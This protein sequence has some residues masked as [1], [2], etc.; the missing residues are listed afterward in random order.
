[1]GELGKRLG[2]AQGWSLLRAHGIDWEVSPQIYP[3]QALRHE[4]ISVEN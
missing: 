4:A 2:K 3:V 1:M